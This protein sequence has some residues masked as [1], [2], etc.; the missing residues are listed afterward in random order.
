MLHVGHCLILHVTV[1]LGG[2]IWYYYC[3]VITNLVIVMTY[4]SIF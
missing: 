2:S 3:D 1:R 4:G